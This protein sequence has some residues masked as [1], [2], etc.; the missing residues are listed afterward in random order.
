MAMPETSFPVFKTKINGH[1]EKF[2][3]SDPA[4]RKQYFSL[5]AGEEIAKLRAYLEAGNTWV[6]FLMGP[7]NSGK[8]TYTKLFME[9][10]GNEHVAHISVGD[11]VR[12]VHKEIENP[13]TRQN[14]IDFLNNNY[15]GSISVEKAIDVILGRDTST[16][17]PTEVVLA[18]VERQIQQIGKK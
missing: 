6:G 12:N 10:V 13:E 3:L 7:K 8:G 18:L 2:S 1:K 15:R 16:L 11:I 4:G 17:L 5:K 14:L 9:A